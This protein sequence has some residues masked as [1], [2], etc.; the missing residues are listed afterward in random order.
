MTRKKGTKASTKSGSRASGAR[1]TSSKTLLKSRNGTILLSGGNPQIEKGYGDAPVQKYIAAMPGWKR[2][3]G[4]RIHDLIVEAVPA[5]EKAIKWNT[6]FYGTKKD[7]WFLGFH[8]LTRYV[9]I[10]FF[11]G[12]ELSP[13]PP[14][15]SKQKD[16]R[17]LDIYEGDEIDEPL[18]SN[19]VKLA[20][21]LP[22]KRI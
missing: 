10:A 9:K 6:A 15:S 16:V 5:V 18:F 21:K 4:K 22:G 8:C 1:N 13:L 2:N 3:V 7:S 14:G 20:S 17:Y 11:R 19:W 12:A